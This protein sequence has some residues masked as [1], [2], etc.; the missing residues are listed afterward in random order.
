MVREEVTI[1]DREQAGYLL[2]KKLLL[3]KNSN[4]LVVGLGHGG[5]VVGY[6]VAHALQ[7]SF[8]VIPCRKIKHPANSAQTIGSVSMNEVLMLEDI[9]GIP[10]D[11]IYHQ[12]LLSRIGIEREFNFYYANKPRPIIEN[13]TVIIADDVLEEGNAIIACLRSIKKQNPT[14]VVVAI[15]IVTAA[16]FRAISLEADDVVFLKKESSNEPV[17]NIYASLPTVKEEE[18][19]DLLLKSMKSTV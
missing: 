6:H 10:Q 5:A 4:A 2:S 7:L 12:I 16:A 19:R 14:D 9:H 11:Y 1:Q 15:P 3:Y 8:A 18:V 13:R 17:R